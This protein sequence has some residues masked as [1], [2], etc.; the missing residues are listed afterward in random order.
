M[1]DIY[2]Q[3]ISHFCSIVL[4]R[5]RAFSLAWLD[6]PKITARLLAIP[7]SFQYLVACHGPGDHKHPHVAFKMLRRSGHPV[8]HMSQH[9][10]TILEDAALKF[11]ECLARLLR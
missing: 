1:R 11:C 8:E 10:A 9:H 7:S 2:A 4:L 3:V 6:I 5:F